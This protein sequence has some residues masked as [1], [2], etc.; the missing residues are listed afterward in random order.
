[1]SR[2]YFGVCIAHI[3]ALLAVSL[4]AR[5]ATTPTAGDLARCAG[6]AA[7]DARLACYDGLAG[8]SADRAA[9][10]AETAA[11]S[12][13]AAASTAAPAIRAAPTTPA[14]TAPAPA[15]AG[16]AQNFGLTPA[17]RH[18]APEGP[19]AIQARIAKIIED[20]RVGRTYVVLDNGQTWSFTDA[21]EDARL[22]P[23]DPVTIKHAALGSF[24]MTTASRH[25][26]HVRRTQ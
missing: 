19:A 7:P 21:E 4:P 10:A 6:I 15:A 2:V 5:S 12:S 3:A 20:R 11:R 1:V 22:G 25:T 8:R 17:Q 13:T 26:Y 23:G 18:Q 14:A 24:V 9:T 16:E